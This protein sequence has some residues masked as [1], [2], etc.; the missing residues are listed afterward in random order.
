MRYAVLGAGAIGTLIGAAL[1]RNGHEV[2]L[3]MRRETLEGYTGRVTVESAVLG[4]FEVDLPASAALDRN[5]DVLWVAVKAT[6][7]SP[8]LELAP[9]ESMSGTTVVPL[10]NGVDHVV[11]LRER[12]ADVV[13]GAIR[14]E[15]E[16]AGTAHIIQRSP[17][18]RIELAGAADVAAELVAAGIE[19]RTRD[20]EMSLLW[21]KLVFL[22]PVALATTA[23][24]APLGAVR[25]D[26]RFGGCLDEALAVA[27]VL[28]ARVD[29]NAVRTLVKAAPTTM[30]SSMQ[31]DVAAGRAPELD[32]I[33]G[34]IL[35]GGSTHGIPVRIPK[36]SLAWS[37]LAHP[38]EVALKR[39]S[40]TSGSWQSSPRGHARRGRKWR[41]GRKIRRGR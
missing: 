20:D 38:R 3:L 1:R 30:R 13:A 10:M 17:F 6:S 9:P 37:R 18:M 26:V 27:G 21:E 31:K 4:D 34:P 8:A 15:S 40:R 19:A 11:L 23:M 25:H 16:R 12:Y 28:G 33:A 39:H 29:E 32:A 41:T 5:V 14:V 22:A 36:N 35:R 24:A 7:L 2:V